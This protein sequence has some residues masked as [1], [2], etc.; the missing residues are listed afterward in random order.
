MPC[1]IVFDFELIVHGSIL[2][3]FRSLISVSIWKEASLPLLSNVSFRSSADIFRIGKKKKKE[4][5]QLSARLPSDLRSTLRWSAHS[6]EVCMPSSQSFT[7]GQLMA[8]LRVWTGKVY[9]KSWRT[10]SKVLLKRLKF[11]P[12]PVPKLMTVK[13][14]IWMS[15]HLCSAVMFI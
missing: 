4:E 12:C 11:F 1:T 7:L 15:I 8:G 14:G 9:M 3:M 13:D 2:K 6:G 5:N 10:F